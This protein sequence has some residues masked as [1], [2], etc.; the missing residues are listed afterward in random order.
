MKFRF[1]SLIAA[2]VPCLLATNAFAQHAGDVE[3]GYDSLATPSSLIVEVIESTSEG[4]ALF[5]ADFEEL[6]PFNAGDFSADEPGFNTNPGEGLLVNT[7]DQIWL[8]V[9]DASV[10]SSFGVGYVNYFN[11]TT[12]MLENSGRM[13]VLGNSTSVGDL[14]LNGGSIESGSTR[15]FIDAGDADQ[16]IHDHVVFDLLDDASAPIGAYGLLMELESDFDADGTAELVS[17]KF[18]L[19]FNYGM[20]EG[21]FD[22]R[23]LASFGLSSV[24]EP[25]SLAFLMLGAAAIGLKRR[26]NAA[27]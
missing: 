19:V 21:D 10:E 15:Q 2:A 23:A 9:L 12:N 26:R 1:L 7:G 24:P 8:N 20:D 27:C 14:F 13:S 4:I 3:V 6:D 16:E 11:P 18:W 25:G 5:E 22:D 17:D